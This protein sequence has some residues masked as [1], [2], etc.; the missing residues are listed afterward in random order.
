MRG[1][2]EGP[3]SWTRE[4]GPPSVLV[5]FCLACILLLACSSTFL[6]KCTLHSASIAS[7][8]D[9]LWKSGTDRTSDPQNHRTLDEVRCRVAPQ[10][11]MGI[12]FLGRRGGHPVSRV[13]IFDFPLYK[14]CSVGPKPHPNG[15]FSK[16]SLWSI[17]SGVG[18]ETHRAK[19]FYLCGQ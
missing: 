5:E 2:K 3:C 14:S 7:V 4:Q 16:G 10:L 17:A 1:R 11:K 6:H 18:R 8:Q 9:Q 19:Y 12:A 13:H 15:K